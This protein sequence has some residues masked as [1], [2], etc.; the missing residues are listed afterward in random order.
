MKDRF[1][2]LVTHNDLDGAGCAVL[3]KAAYP[4]A[5]VLHEGYD[6]VDNAISKALDLVV[7]ECN[8]LLVIAD[9]SP[10]TDIIISSLDD[11]ANRGT[12]EVALVDHHITAQEKL[13]GYKWAHFNDVACGTVGMMNWLISAGKEASVEHLYKFT[14]LVNDY[15]MW[16]HKHKES[17]QLNDLMRFMGIERFVQR[18]FG[19]HQPTYFTPAEQLI[20]EVSQETKN[21]YIQE[22]MESGF[23][24]DDQ[25]ILMF[26][27][28]AERYPSEIG[29]ECRRRKLDAS[30]LAVVDMKNNKVSLRSIDPS[31]DV[32]YFAKHKRGGGHKASAGFEFTDCLKHTMWED[33]IL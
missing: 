21:K 19:I 3:F 14:D 29:E 27:V 32:S 22:A 16:I 18:C 10:K 31:F 28:Y 20:L 9:L 30:F 13:S 8:P 7:G 15:D 23:Y 4:N 6:T 5:I 17:K 12:L 24:H 1:A 26:V 25:G 2:V 33:G 11:F